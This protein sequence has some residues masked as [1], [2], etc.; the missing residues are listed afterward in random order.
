VLNKTDYQIIAKYK[1][2]YR[3]N[4]DTCHCDRGY[5]IEDGCGLCYTC[6][7][8][9]RNQHMNVD[10]APSSDFIVKNGVR[11][12]KTTCHT[13]GVDRGYIHK[14]N[15]TKCCTSCSASIRNKKRYDSNNPKIIARRRLRH[16]MKSSIARKMRIRGFSKSGESI[17]KILPYSVD[18]LKNHLESK[19]ESGMTWDNYG[20]WEIDHITPDSWFKYNSTEDRGFKDSWSLNNLQPLWKVDN[21][22]KGNRYEG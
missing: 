9:K 2:K 10:P 21:A 12:Y 3:A 22:S 4:C 8:Q 6:A 16:S 7:I 15:I 13:C 14:K 1:K 20:K 19:F 18:D 11:H 5:L 17:N